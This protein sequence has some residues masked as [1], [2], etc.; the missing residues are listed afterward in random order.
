[1]GRGTG[2]TFQCVGPILE[3]RHDSCFEWA[4]HDLG[5]SGGQQGRHSLRRRRGRKHHP[6]GRF[7]GFHQPNSL[8][9]HKRPRGGLYHFQ[10]LPSGQLSRGGSQ[11]LGGSSA[12]L[13]NREQPNSL[14]GLQCASTGI[15][16]QHGVGRRRCFEL[17]D[18]REYHIE[19]RRR[20]LYQRA[21]FPRPDS[22]RGGGLYV[23][24]A[25]V[26]DP[27]AQA[28]EVRPL[29]PPE[30]ASSRPFPLFLRFHPSRFRPAAASA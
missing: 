9:H 5:R 30:R 14:G 4:L 16:R 17:C 24:A 3:W 6:R 29:Q 23:D 10:W 22:G 12:E 28:Q 27:P 1:M 11:P 15:R 7:S 13:P 20:G 21:A 2:L 18:R 19:L 25:L 26:I 8:H